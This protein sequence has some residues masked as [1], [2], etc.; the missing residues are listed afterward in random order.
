MNRKN[1]KEEERKIFLLKLKKIKNLTGE[2]PK[3]NRVTWEGVQG[4]RS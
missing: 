1:D 4:G 2:K 3:E